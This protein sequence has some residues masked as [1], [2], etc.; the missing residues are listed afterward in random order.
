MQY[1]PICRAIAGLWAVFVVLAPANVRAAEAKPAPAA[2]PAVADGFLAPLKAITGDEQKFVDQMW[3]VGQAELDRIKTLQYQIENRKLNSADMAKAIREIPQHVANLKALS[4]YSMQRYGHNARVRNFRGTVLYDALGKET[5]GVKE[6]LVAVSL[7]KN[8]SDPYNN[9]GM[10]YFHVGRYTLG[11]QNMDRALKLEPKNPDY[12]FNMAQSYLI[13]RQQTAKARGWSL[14]KV[15]KE[16]MKLSKKAAELAPDD[17]QIL[18]DYAVNFLA[19]ENFG[20]KANWHKA[21]EAWQA[22]RSHA[23]GKEERF[24]TWLNE[25]RVWRYDGDKKNAL[26]CLKE[27]LALRPNSE[28]TQRLIDKTS[29]ES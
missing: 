27:A 4:E 5:E 14:K 28:V 7:D 26:R 13:F 23:P 9:L 18:Q 25:G 22:A 19:A 16:A 11:F 8:Y 10:Y 21:A 15:Y 24:Y 17:F 6:W 29:S 20:V 2:L 12:C 1:P 3:T